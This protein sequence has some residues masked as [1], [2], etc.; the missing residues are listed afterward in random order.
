MYGI[1]FGPVGV[2]VCECE[3]SNLPKG[4]KCKCMVKN[5]KNSKNCL[6]IFKNELIA[7]TVETFGVDIVFG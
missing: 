4:Y 6:P 1:Q 2:F 5:N 7:K 3:W